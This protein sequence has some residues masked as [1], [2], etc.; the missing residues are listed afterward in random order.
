MC[1]AGAEASHT[2]ESRV[3]GAGENVWLAWSISTC[4]HWSSVS[5]LRCH[6]NLSREGSTNGLFS[7]R[8]ERKLWTRVRLWNVAIV[9]GPAGIDR[10]DHTQRRRTSCDAG[11]RICNYLGNFCTKWSLSKSIA[12]ESSGNLHLKRRMKK[13][14][15]ETADS[16]RVQKNKNIPFNE[17]AKRRR[18]LIPK[19]RNDEGRTITSKC[20]I[21]NVFGECCI[22]VNADERSWR[23]VARQNESWCKNRQ[24]WR[25]Q[26]WGRQRRNTRDL[27][28]KS[29][30]QQ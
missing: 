22:I 17:S 11:R 4:V 24:R 8:W 30:R 16:W 9:G 27:L 2:L 12:R 18:T 20:G 7:L 26:R 3:G 23:R 10:G 1:Q 29:Y 28:M 14:R 25:R 6:T 5:E 19:I 13:V 15:K 21:A